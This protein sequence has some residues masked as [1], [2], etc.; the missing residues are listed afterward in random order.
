M[1]DLSWC[2]VDDVATVLGEILLAQDPAAH[3]Y[4]VENPQRQPW[5]AMIPLLADELGVSRRNIVPFPEWLDRM[6]LFPDAKANPAKRVEAFLDDHFVR[7]ACGGVTLDTQAAQER[8]PRLKEVGVVG[9]DL[10]KRYVQGWRD[11]GF[12]P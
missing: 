5:S 6:R 8:S 3:I 11:V 2:P 1:K 10:I 12:I 4:H 9:P 7:M